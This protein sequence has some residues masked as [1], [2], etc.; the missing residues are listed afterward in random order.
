LCRVFNPLL[1]TEEIFRLDCS[2]PGPVPGAGQFFMLKPG[3]SAVFLPRPI[4]AALWETEGPP[5]RIS[6]FIARRG[7]GTE[8][9][10]A[11]REGEGIEMS[12]PLGNR[13]VD[14]L[15][16]GGQKPVALVGGGLGIAPLLSIPRE[17]PGAVFDFYGGFRNNVRTSGERSA[18]AGA[19]EGRVRKRVLAA[20]AGA[21]GEIRAGRITDFFDPGEYG[22][23][24]VCGP[25]PMLRA[26]AEKCRAARVPCYVSLERR[27]ACGTGACLGCT[28]ETLHG[29]R[30]CCADGPIFGAEEVFFTGRHRLE[31][32]G[33]GRAGVR[34][35]QTPEGSLP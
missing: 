17:Q 32:S 34:R 18:L 5:R 6:F 33:S 14:F 29:S 25:D 28:V 10:A 16:P 2:W 4:S 12:G 31:T 9:L 24:C 19:V 1:I 8:E 7:R 21:A 22:A 3:R 35:K 15:P 11:L 23:V 13:W 20:E 30:R 26:A 27:M